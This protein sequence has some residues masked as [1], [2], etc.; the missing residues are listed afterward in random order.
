MEAALRRSHRLAPAA[1]YYDP[2][3]RLWT[4]RFGLW[5]SGFRLWTLPGATIARSALATSFRGPCHRPECRQTGSRRDKL[6]SENR[7]T[8]KD[9]TPPSHLRAD[10]APL[11]L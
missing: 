1:Y 10:R 9:A 7:P 2:P 4:S 3:L 11:A 8:G 5:T 6:K